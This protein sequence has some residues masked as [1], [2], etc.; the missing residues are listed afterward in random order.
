MCT[1]ESHAGSARWGGSRMSVTV[2]RGIERRLRPSALLGRREDLVPLGGSVVERLL[3]VLLS[4]YNVLHLGGHDL[5][6]LDGVGHA[7]ER[8]ARIRQ[9]HLL[10]KRLEQRLLLEPCLIGDVLP[11]R[12][13]AGALG[14]HLDS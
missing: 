12:E 10:G 9:L 2:S 1:R 8:R 13:S 5:V 3:G 11:R 14:P 7:E 6:H 4:L